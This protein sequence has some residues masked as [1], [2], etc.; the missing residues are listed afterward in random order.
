VSVK[1]CNARCIDAYI[2]LESGIKGRATFVY[3][4]P[5]RENRSEFWDF[6]RFMRAQ[7]D[8]PWI[9]CGDFNEVLSQDEHIGPRDR[10]EAQICAFQDCLQDCE[11]MDLG[12][13]GPKFTWNNRQGCDTNVKCCLDRAIANGDFSRMFENCVVENLI[14]TSSDHY[15]I[16][17]ILSGISSV[18]MQPPVQQGF[19][20]E[21]MWLRTPDYREHLEKAWAE[22]SAGP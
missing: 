11:L 8:G 15:V 22:G 21:A 5:Q 1:T 4:E 17:I 16:L 6:L 13:E 9:C 10:T 12:F 2:T 3:G 14:T 20:F 19:R 18:A 7:W